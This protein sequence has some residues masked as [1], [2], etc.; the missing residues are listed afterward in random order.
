MRPPKKRSI[1]VA[2]PVQFLV[3]FLRDL[4]VGLRR[5][6]GDR[7]LFPDFIADP[8]G[9]VCLVGKHRLAKLQPI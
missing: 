2:L 4:A 3:E 5:D 6:H 1:F 9:I 8:V 7:T